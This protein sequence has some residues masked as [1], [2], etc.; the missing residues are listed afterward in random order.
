MP[1]RNHESVGPEPSLSLD[2][3]LCLALHSAARA[4]SKAYGEVLREKG[5]TYPQYLVLLCL[6]EDDGLTV[7][8]LGRLL[9]LD[10]GTLTPVVKRLEAEGLVARQRSP[11]DE[12]KVEVWLT[13]T[14]RAK[15][16]LALRARRHVIEK[17]GMDD[18]EIA[19]MRGE[20]MEIAARL[21]PDP[22]KNRI[23]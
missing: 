3:Q 19:E 17:L 18:D 13:K 6:F 1:K 8:E 2:D 12:R 16:A 14:G 20:L 23:A 11:A 15:R 10:S 4:I 9:G 7:G 22:R 5:V 21:S